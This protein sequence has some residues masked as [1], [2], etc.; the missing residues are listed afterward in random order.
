MTRLIVVGAVGLGLAAITA[1]VALQAARATTRHAA[2]VP[3]VN[4]GSLSAAP[5]PAQQAPGQQAPGQQAPVRQSGGR[6]SAT[7]SSASSWPGSVPSGS[8]LQLASIGL[9]APIVGVT[10]DGNVMQVPADPRV[11]GW[12]TG[13]AA[14]GVGTGNTVIVGHINYAGVSG[15]L[16]A[17]PHA[18]P[19]QLFTLAEPER[20]QSYRVQAVRTYPKTSGLPA[21][22]FTRTGPAELVVITCGGPFDSGSG[23]YEDNIVAYA[24]PA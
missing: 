17:L 9:D 2:A 14:P 15:A 20:T 16:A 8:R 19:G 3:V 24:T 4:V 6:P 13:G 18:R 21:A 1:A 23:N 10:T 22:I 12:W 5:P 11:L 7:R